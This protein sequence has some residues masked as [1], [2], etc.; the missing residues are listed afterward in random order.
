MSRSISAIP[1]LVCL[2]MPLFAENGWVTGTITVD[3]VPSS[4]CLMKLEGVE[5]ATDEGGC[6]FFDHVAPG[7]HE[8]SFEGELMRVTKSIKV[9]AGPNVIPPQEMI[10]EAGPLIA[11]NCDDAQTSPW[12]LPKCSDY[13]LDSALIAALDHGDLSTTKLLEQRRMRVDNY[14]ERQRIADAL[15][16][17]GNKDAALWDE[18]YA[19]AVNCL[20]FDSNGRASSNPEYIRFCEEHG[21]DADEYSEVAYRALSIIR[22]DG[23]AHALMLQ[24]LK[25]GDEVIVALAVDG[26][27]KQGGGL[28]NPPHTP[29]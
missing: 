22:E 21:Y 8:L 3:G 27:A 29:Q 11:V 20:R 25:A 9:V 28:E 7:P 23:R 5:V 16:Q 17:H 18:L 14:S 10:P 12:Y 1:L 26:L 19:D 4:G 13:D 15:L 6:Y 24:A 2:A